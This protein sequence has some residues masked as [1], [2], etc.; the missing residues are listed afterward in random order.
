MPTSRSPLHL[1]GEYAL[2]LT[3]LTLP[4]PLQADRL[5]DLENYEAV[6]LFIRRARAA[7][8]EFSLTPQNAASV[9]EICR[10]LDGLPLAI[11]LATARLRVLPPQALLERLQHGLPLLSGGAQH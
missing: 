5:E 4:D 6:Q 1:S 11:E 7:C 8:G 9:V 2:P 3:T 10:K